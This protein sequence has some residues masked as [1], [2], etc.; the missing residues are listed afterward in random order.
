MN[1]SHL[2]NQARYST[3]LSRRSFDALSSWP[4]LKTVGGI[5]FDS[6]DIVNRV[7]RKAAPLSIKHYDC[8]PNG[9]MAYTGDYESDNIKACF[10]Q[11]CREKRRGQVSQG[12]F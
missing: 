5:A 7:L 2:L 1:R 8:G 10:N 4:G 3:Q 11:L 12:F 9:C 6:S